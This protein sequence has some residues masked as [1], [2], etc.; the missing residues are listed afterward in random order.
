[1]SLQK[2][3]SDTIKKLI[4]FI[5]ITF[6]LSCSTSDKNIGITQVVSEYYKT[7]QANTDFEKFMDF[8]SEEIELEDIIN[9]DKIIGKDN[10]KNFFDWNNPNLN[11]NDS[12]AL[13]I[14]DQIIDDNKVVTKGYF[15]PFKWN[16]MQIEAMHFTT[17]LYYD[18][19]NKIIKQ[20]DWIN[21][22]SFLVDYEKRNNS[23][24]WIWN[25]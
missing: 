25:N 1:M 23:N 2:K 24:K 12:L 9:G 18:K 4:F 3:Y 10:L 16:E 7:Y 8:Y 19:S 11:R 20:V 17:I 14:E 22:P 5:L 15:T 6:F 21:Y 13:I